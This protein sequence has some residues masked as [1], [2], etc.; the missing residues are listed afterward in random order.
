MDLRR[1]PLGRSDRQH[2]A[3]VVSGELFDRQPAAADRGIIDP[4]V[5]LVDALQDDEVPEGPV[6]NRR[7]QPIVQ[8]RQALLENSALEAKVARALRDIA[9]ARAVAGDPAQGAQRHRR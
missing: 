8:L 5:C 2:H 1:H 4:G 9:D 3:R 7:A 6:Q